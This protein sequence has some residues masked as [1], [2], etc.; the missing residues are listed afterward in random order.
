MLAIRGNNFFSLGMSAIGCL[1]FRLLC[2][3]HF[4]GIELELKSV[5]FISLAAMLLALPTHSSSVL[6]FVGL[7]F[8]RFFVFFSSSIS[9]AKSLYPREAVCFFHGIIP[10]SLLMAVEMALRFVPLLAKEAIEVFSIQKARSA[11]VRGTFKMRISAFMLPFFVRLFRI[12]DRVAFSLKSRK[13]SPEKNRIVVPP[14]MIL[15]TL[16]LIKEQ[17]IMSSNAS[18]NQD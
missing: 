16:N 10:L 12:A 3:R 5:T 2:C 4:S 15:T 14:E 11:F 6:E 7:I 9:F 18:K 17:N 1:I 13:I 8:L